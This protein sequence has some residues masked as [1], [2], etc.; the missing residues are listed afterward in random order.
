MFTTHQMLRLLRLRGE[1][2]D[3]R[4]EPDRY[5]DDLDVAQESV[6]EG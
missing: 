2:L 4:L 3:S 1:T 5:R 6:A